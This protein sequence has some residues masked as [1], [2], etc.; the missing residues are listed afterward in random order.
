MSTADTTTTD[1]LDDSEKTIIDL[2]ETIAGYRANRDG[3][4]KEISELRHRNGVLAAG[5]QKVEHD[6]DSA[7]R[8][9]DERAIIEQKLRAQISE[10]SAECREARDEATALRGELADARFALAEMAQ[11]LAEA[12]SDARLSYGRVDIR[13]PTCL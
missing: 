11:A 1:N 7:K 3:I 4:L 2:R 13:L 10:S 9:S 5:L 12:R 8:E 6:R